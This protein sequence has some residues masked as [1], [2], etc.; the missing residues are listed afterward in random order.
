[1]RKLLRD[2]RVTVDYDMLSEGNLI[3]P[4][5][6]WLLVA[7][8]HDF[9]EIVPLLASHLGVSCVS[10]CISWG[11]HLS[12]IA[13]SRQSQE[14][15]TEVL[16][17]SWERRATL[18]QQS[19]RVRYLEVNHSALENIFAEVPTIQQIEKKVLDD[20]IIQTLQSLYGNLTLILLKTYHQDDLKRLFLT[21]KFQ[22]ALKEA[23][24]FV[25][26]FSDISI[27][28]IVQMYNTIISN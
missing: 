13:L 20:L 19:Q 6:D 3:I 27:P 24:S 21:E 15:A 8:K 17:E 7:I 11:S 16:V 18:E 12:L 22:Q 28:V 4:V 25:K 14:I 1:M 23:E 26:A 5:T 10:T 2:E 9:Y